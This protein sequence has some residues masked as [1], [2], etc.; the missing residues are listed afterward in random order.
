ML[1]IYRVL[2][3][4]V[5]IHGLLNVFVMNY[6]VDNRAVPVLTALWFAIGYARVFGRNFGASNFKD[7]FR[8]VLM[9][10]A[11]PFATRAN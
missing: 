9:A 8:G 10:G 7:A 3:A 2:F 11:W 1:N 4:A 6:L 5:V